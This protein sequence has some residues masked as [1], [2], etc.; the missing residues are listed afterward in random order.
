M[1]LLRLLGASALLSA[2]PLGAALSVQSAF[3]PNAEVALYSDAA[4]VNAT[5]FGAE[6]KKL[7]DVFKNL[8]KTGGADASKLMDDTFLK[9]LGLEEKD[10][11]SFAGSFKGIESVMQGGKPEV[12]LALQ[13]GKKIDG[14]KLMELIKKQLAE[15]APE[16]TVTEITVGTSK[17]YAIKPSKQDAEAPDFHVFVS[18]DLPKTLVLAGT[19]E[20]LKAAMANDKGAVGANL[21]AP[22]AQHGTPQMWLSVVLPEAVKAQLAAATAG[23]PMGPGSNQFGT[24][25]SLALSATCGTDLKVKLSVDFAKPEAASLAKTM[26]ETMVIPMAKMQLADPQTG[27]APSW[28]NGLS[29]ASVG[30]TAVF[31]IAMTSKDVEGLVATAMK[32]AGA[33]PAGEDEAPVPAPVKPAPSKSAPA[34]PAPVK[35]APAPKADAAK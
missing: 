5:P 14:A 23:N 1:K 30:N 16:A 11:I 32:Q 13:L 31:T 26:L 34:K 28:T 18:S 27:A 15:S 21:K 33:A 2:A 35:P 12:A 6:M 3:L 20:G 8:A 4:A 24:A 25:Q 17:V 22:L 7:Q 9:E 29:V 10:V 19:P